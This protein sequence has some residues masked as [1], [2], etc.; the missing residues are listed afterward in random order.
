MGRWSCL[1]GVWGGGR[2]L[3]KGS[4]VCRGGN[5]DWQIGKDRREVVLISCNEP[6]MAR[7]EGTDQ[8]VRQWSFRYQA[9]PFSLDEIVPDLVRADD[10]FPEPVVAEIYS[11]LNQELILKR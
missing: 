7:R 9:L 5:T 8:N 4:V 6:L 11:Y 2:R 1:R 3:G 10:I